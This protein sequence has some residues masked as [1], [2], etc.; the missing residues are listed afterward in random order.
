MSKYICSDQLGKVLT[1]TIVNESKIEVFVAEIIHNYHS[2]GQENHRFYERKQKEI[3]V[4]YTKNDTLGY[5]MREI[6][7]ILSKKVEY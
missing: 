1:N 4:M 6:K 3:T 2:I 5:E 7:Q